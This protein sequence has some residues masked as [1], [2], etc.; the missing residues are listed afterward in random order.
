MMQRTSNNVLTVAVARLCAWWAARR[1]CRWCGQE[2]RL[3][4]L[5]VGRRCWELHHDA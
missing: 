1:V 5:L 3:P 4:G 2:P